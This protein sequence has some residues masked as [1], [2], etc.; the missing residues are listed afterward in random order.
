MNVGWVDVGAIV[1]IVAIVVWFWGMG[2]SK[3]PEHRHH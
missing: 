1:L 2:A 3:K